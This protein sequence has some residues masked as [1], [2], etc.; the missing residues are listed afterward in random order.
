MPGIVVPIY[1][2]VPTGEMLPWKKWFLKSTLVQRHGIWV[3]ACLD[4]TQQMVRIF[5]HAQ[6]VKMYFELWVHVIRL[7]LT[8]Y[9][10]QYFLPEL[11]ISE[12]NFKAWCG[13][14]RGWRPCSYFPCRVIGSHY[15]WFCIKTAVEIGFKKHKHQRYLRTRD[16]IVNYYP[17]Y[18]ISLSFGWI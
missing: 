11:L 7:H 9:I 12:T 2:F 4:I 14:P 5:C 1:L 13:K 8:G 3:L 6:K 16:S 18:V 17:A 15:L 10:C